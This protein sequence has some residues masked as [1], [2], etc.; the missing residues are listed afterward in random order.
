MNFTEFYD[1]VR[2]AQDTVNKQ[3]IFVR[4]MAWLCKGCLRLAK[5]DS[6]DLSALKR[7]L[8]DWNMRT[9]TWKKKG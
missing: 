4:K 3:H 2:E 8:M 1:A 9:R 5:V 7:E 6:D